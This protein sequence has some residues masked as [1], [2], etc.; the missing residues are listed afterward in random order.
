MAQ[1]C[2]AARRKGEGEMETIELLAN[3]GKKVSGILLAVIPFSQEM[4]ANACLEFRPLRAEDERSFRE[5]VREFQD[6]SP[7]FDFALGF[8][9]SLS[10]PEYVRRLDDWPSGANLP[11]GFVPGSFYV[12]VVDG[13]VVGRLSLRHRLNEFLAKVGGHIGYGVRRSERGR[14]YATEMVRRSLPVCA[15]LGIERALITCDVDNA[16]SIK[17]IE[18]CGGILEGVTC[19]PQLEIQKRRYWV[20]TSTGE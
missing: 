2:R 3:V 5:A 12:G 17:V 8:D 14:G 20:K 13:V 11:A 4:N 15:K 7:P 9:A 16:G 19:D 10:F 6:E 1:E 18:R